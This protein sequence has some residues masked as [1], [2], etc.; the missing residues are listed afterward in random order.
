MPPCQPSLLPRHNFSP[1]FLSLFSLQQCREMGNESCGQV[2]TVWFCQERTPHTLYLVQCGTIPQGLC[3]S[4]GTNSS[5][6][7]SSLS[8]STG[9]ARSLIQ[10]GLPMGHS[11][12]QATTCFSLGSTMG[13]RGI[14][15]L[16]GSIMGY[17]G[18][19]APTGSS[20]G[21]RGTA[22]SP[23]CAPQPAGDFLFLSL[24]HLL[25]LLPH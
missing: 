13:Y 17:G 5:S 18:T 7:G 19:C 3:P 24:E 20:M 15:A 4:S 8:G 11:L 6:L 25:Q 14:C 22:A 1:D 21:Y 12:F 9:P 16:T 2:I 23:R 10:H